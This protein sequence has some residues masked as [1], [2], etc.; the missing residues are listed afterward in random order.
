[1]KKNFL[2]FLLLIISI[3][4]Y[5]QNI[6]VIKIT[7]L[8]KRIKNNSDTTYIVNF[9]A[10]WCAPCIKE[11]PDISAFVASH[12]NVTAIGLAYEDTDKADIVAFLKK[13]PVAYPVAQVDVANPPKDFD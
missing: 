6:N 13:H 11:M 10:T 7:D 9:W 12:K 4:S 2:F 3:A 8:E 1:M 5:S